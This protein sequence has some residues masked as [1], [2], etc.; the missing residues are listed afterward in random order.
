MHTHRRA[1]GTVVSVLPVLA[2][3]ALALLLVPLVVVVCGCRGTGG[4]GA[5]AGSGSCA[6]ADG[7]S[8]RGRNCAPLDGGGAHELTKQRVPTARGLL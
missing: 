6:A 8:R 7:R 2:V 1:D 3:V 5:G 4:G